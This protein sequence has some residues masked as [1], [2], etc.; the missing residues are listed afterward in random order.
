MTTASV[1][2]AGALGEIAAAAPAPIAASFDNANRE[3]TATGTA[4]GL[5]I[6]A[7]APQFALPDQLGR[8]IGLEGQ[9]ARGPVVLVFYRGDW[10]PYC[11]LTLRH[12]QAELAAIRATGAELVAISPQAPDRALTVAEKHE[13]EFPVLS[14]VE[15][16]TIAAYKL[17]Y[18]VPL[19]L[20]R[21]YE[22]FGNDLRQQNADGTWSLPV[23]ATFVIDADGVIRARFVDADFTKRM[24]PA[25]ITS[26]LAELPASDRGRDG[27]TDGA[28]RRSS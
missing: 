3:L 25:E 7:N 23:P 10:C 4:P 27:N 22:E 28:P 1:S 18:T 14:D 6:G 15:Q 17:R 19:A 24:E 26:V 21:V 9:L 16:A 13:L 20:Q 12:L 5:E 8:V 11:N 2:L